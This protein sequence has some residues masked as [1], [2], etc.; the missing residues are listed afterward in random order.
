MRS[1]F[2]VL[3]NL[4]YIR[5]PQIAHEDACNAGSRG[6]WPPSLG[7]LLRERPGSPTTC[8]VNTCAYCEPLPGF[9]PVYARV[10][11]N[12][13]VGVTVSTVFTDRLSGHRKLA[14]RC[15]GR[16]RQRVP[17]SCRTRVPPSRAR[18]AFDSQR[19]HLSLPSSFDRPHT[20]PW[21]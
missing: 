2:S 19:F 17:F 16:S 9:L 14:V 1:F 13:H 6:I 3:R 20:V 11:A 12:T 21:L 7:T 4:S 15:R 18:I 8:L 10:Y 5:L